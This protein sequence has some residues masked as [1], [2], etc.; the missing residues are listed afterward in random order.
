MQ[1]F[2]HSVDG[3][4]RHIIGLGLA[5]VLTMLPSVARGQQQ[6]AA[7]GGSSGGNHSAGLQ[8]GQVWPAGKIGQNQTDSSTAPGIFYEYAAS[9]MFALQINVIRSSHGDKLTLLAPTAGIKANLFYFDQLVPYAFAGVGLYFVDRQIGSSTARVSTSNFGVNLGLGADLDLGN[10]FF[11]GLWM[12]LHNLFSAR[13]LVPQ[14]GN[15][16][17]NSGRWSAFFIRAGMRF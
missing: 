13:K 5:L 2:R 3:L 9:Q 4:A 16:E 15:L 8:L 11:F 17:E 1:V 6:A 14:T 10:S 12:G 7:A